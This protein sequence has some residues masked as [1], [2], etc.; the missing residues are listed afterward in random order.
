MV[1]SKFCSTF[2][3]LQQNNLELGIMMTDNCLSSVVSRKSVIIPSKATI[4]EIGKMKDKDKKL[5]ALM[6]Y[7]LLVR[8]TPD[9]LEMAAKNQKQ[10]KTINGRRFDV[11]K[12]DSK[13]FKLNGKKIK[14]LD[15]I[16][17]RYFIY[18]ASSKL[19]PYPPEGEKREKVKKDISK[20]VKDIGE[21]KK[22]SKVK[23][24]VIIKGGSKS[25]RKGLSSMNMYRSLLQ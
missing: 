13:T 21:Q 22:K 19:V 6:S 10:I 11:E 4:T 3:I 5:N 2:D 20:F 15:D 17:G 16:G 18:K 8:Y 9:Q 23:K 12:V 25:R 14:V 7:I 24:T 1:R